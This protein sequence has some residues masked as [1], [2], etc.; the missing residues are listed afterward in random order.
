MLFQN[1]PIPISDLPT[2]SGQ[3]LEPL[4]PAYLKVNQISNILFFLVLFCILSGLYFFAEF[5]IHFT[6]QWGIAG[7]WLLL[8]MFTLWH[9]WRN[10]QVQ[11][12]LVREHDLT[13]RTGVFF[14]KTIVIPYNRV[15]H[16]EVRQGPIERYF[17][18]R[19]IEVFTAGGESSD[20]SIPGLASDR[21]E[22]LKAF[23]IQKTGQ[24]ENS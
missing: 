17:N 4:T 1:P 19:R 2:L 24:Y 8:F 3:P 18:L 5:N 13:Y 9:T 14:R 7:A 15:Q 23:V 10:F 11:G 6:V 22:Q 20:L 21:A 16:C 12:F